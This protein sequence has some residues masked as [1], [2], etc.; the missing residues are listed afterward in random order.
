[1][2][3]LVDK[4][5]GRPLIIIGGLL[6]G[7][8]LIYIQTI[9]TYLP[10]LLVY[11]LVVAVGTH[12]GFGQTL[13]T[14]VNRWFVRR[15]AIALT[16][17][18]TGFAAGGA[19][20][21]FPLGIGVDS[22]GWRPTLLYSGIFVLCVSLLL[23]LVIRHSPESMGIP[24]EGSEADDD[25]QDGDEQTDVKVRRSTPVVD[26]SVHQ[27]MRTRV[28]WVMLAASTLRISAETGIM[29]H[30]IPIM[31]WKGVDDQTAAGLV[32]VFFFLSIPFRLILGFAGQ[33]LPF[34]PLLAM[35][36]VSAVTGLTL[37]VVS[38]GT[39][40]LYPFVILMSIYEGAVVLQWLAIGSYFGRTS[41]GTLTGII[42]SFD[43]LGTLAMPFFAGW[44][45]DTTGG[46]TPAI[47]TFAAMLGTSGLLYTLARRP[48]PVR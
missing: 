18:L 17:L 23:S 36:V 35:G 10:F 1:M 12:V 45:F 27:A 33:K 25:E 2:G 29:V 14:V 31:V 13:L 30:I 6:A 16:I 47:I 7:I 28:F 11:V 44:V 41:Y 24:V 26:F 19:I 40:G 46:Y 4:Y 21:V 42:R 15:K 8:G 9:K 20:F 38:D 32:S 22:I 43:T 5:G 48:K 37:V 34:Q 3:W 39:W